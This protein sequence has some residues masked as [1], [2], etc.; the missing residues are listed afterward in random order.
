MDEYLLVESGG[1]LS[2]PAGERFVDDADRLARQG[3]DVAL[4]LTQDGVLGA[5][6]D[7]LPGLGGYLRAGGTLWVDAYSL[8]RRGVA[9][10]D[11]MPEARLVDMDD[12]ATRLLRPG[13]R[14]VWH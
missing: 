6:P 13:L 1:P 5:L 4:L 12:V 11:L 10:D 9:E 3:A 7:A 2:G 14:A 8:H